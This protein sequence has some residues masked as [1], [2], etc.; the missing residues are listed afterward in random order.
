MER[1]F[2]AVSAGLPLGTETAW[3]ILDSLSFLAQPISK[4][5]VRIVGGRSIMYIE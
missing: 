3:V 4:G 2:G 1:Q 5:V